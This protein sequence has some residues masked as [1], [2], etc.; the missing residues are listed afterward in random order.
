MDLL[1]K[2][3]KLVQKSPVLPLVR[4]HLPFLLSHIKKKTSCFRPIGLGST[5]SR[6]QVLKPTLYQNIDRQL[7]HAVFS[8]RG[9]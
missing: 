5:L 3:F 1:R 2:N 8:V 4:G 9:S 7:S 6:L